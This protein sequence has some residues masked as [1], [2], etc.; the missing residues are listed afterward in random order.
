MIIDGPNELDVEL[1]RD[2]DRLLI[3]PAALRDEADAL[4]ERLLALDAEGARQCK[5]F[6]LAAQESPV[7]HNWRS[8]T[9]ML[10]VNALRLMQN[11]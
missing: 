7:D 5:A 2:G 11:R 9:D 3:E 4:A 8:A 6:F 10:T 1:R